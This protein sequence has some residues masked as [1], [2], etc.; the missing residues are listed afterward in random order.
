M[1]QISFTDVPEALTA[2]AEIAESCRFEL[3][4]GEETAHVFNPAAMGRDAGELRRLCQEALVAM[5]QKGRGLTPESRTRLD[6]ELAVF[7]ALG[8][9]GFV[10]VVA[11]ILSH[12]RQLGILVAVRGAFP[13]GRRLKGQPTQHC[14]W[15]P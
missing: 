12:C 13:S 5:R 6:D 3:G 7:D 1:S 10:L 11:D 8:F 9:S 15:Q 14:G 4:A 2:A